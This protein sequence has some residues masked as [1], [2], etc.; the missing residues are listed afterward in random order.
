MLG[1]SCS[2]QFYISISNVWLSFLSLPCASPPPCS[3]S[4]GWLSALCTDLVP[5]YSSGINGGLL[6]KLASVVDLVILN[7]ALD[8]S[9]IN[10][11]LTNRAND[12][13]PKRCPLEEINSSFSFYLFAPFF[14]C[15]LIGLASCSHMMFLLFNSLSTPTSPPVLA[16]NHHF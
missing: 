5:D 4:A 2:L 9:C 1:F 8:H 10:L 14:L 15:W 16:C 6:E 11:P 13:H 3:L 12:V 7:M